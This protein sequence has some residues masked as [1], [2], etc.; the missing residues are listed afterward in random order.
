MGL[1]SHR[2]DVTRPP[3]CATCH[4]ACCCHPKLHR[5]QLPQ[6]GQS[7]DAWR[8]EQPPCHAHPRS[9]DNHIPKPTCVTMANYTTDHCRPA[10]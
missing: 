7:E 9:N 10:R 2:A 1:V 8:L 6:R 4:V 5:C 3:L